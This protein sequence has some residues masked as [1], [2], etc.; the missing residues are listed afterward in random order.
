VKENIEYFG[1]LSTDDRHR[2]LISAV[3]L[4]D[5]R[6]VWFTNLSGG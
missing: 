1:G 5:K 3:H 6:D 2:E 4:E